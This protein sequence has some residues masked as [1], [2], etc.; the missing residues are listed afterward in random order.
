MPIQTSVISGTVAH[1]HEADSATGGFLSTGS[2]TGI[3]NLTDGG[4]IVGDGSS[5]LTNLSLGTALQ[6]L[7]V[8]ATGTALEYYT[9]ASG[10]TV[11][12]E[13]LDQH[14]VNNS[15]TESSYLWTPTTALDFNTTYNTIFIF[16]RG[17]TSASLN[18]QCKINALTEYHTQYT[19]NDQGTVTGVNDVSATELDI[20]QTSIMNVARAFSYGIYI[21]T[22]PATATQDTFQYWGFGNTTKGFATFRGHTVNQAAGVDLTSLEIKTSTS[23]YTGTELSVYGVKQ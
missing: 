7:R 11:Y 10:S 22:S 4:L 2:L 19:E 21:T 13:L 20:V 1:K 16:G 17:R 6:Q 23:T 3:T 9:P 12:W 8:S 18:L 14:S 5:Q 15:T